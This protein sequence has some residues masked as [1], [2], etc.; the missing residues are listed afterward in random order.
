MVKSDANKNRIS[1]LQVKIRWHVREQLDKKEEKNDLGSPS[2]HKKE[3]RNKILTS[4][5]L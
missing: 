5:F 2:S 4:E 3:L 1:I